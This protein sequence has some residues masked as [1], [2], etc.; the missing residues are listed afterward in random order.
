[1]KKRETLKKS[2]LTL[3]ILP[4]VLIG[5]III[6]V[7]INTIYG[8]LHEETCDNLDKLGNSFIASMDEIYPG[9]YSLKEYEDEKENKTYVLYKGL[10]PI[11]LDFT[12]F[13]NLKKATEVEY[14]IF[15]DTTRYVTTIFDNDNKRYVNSTCPGKVKS[16]VIKDNES[17]FYYNVRIGDENYFTYYIPI[18][19]ASGQVMGMIGLAKAQE[20]V[21]KLV[22]KAVIPIVLVPLAAIIITAIFTSMYS[23]KLT[24]DIRRVREF[25][26]KVSNNNLTATLNPE[27]YKRKDELYDIAKATTDMRNSLKQLIEMDALTGLHNRRYGEVSFNNHWKRAKESNKPFTI[28][29]CDID[30]FKKVNDNYGHE[31]GDEVLKSVSGILKKHMTE[32]GFAIRWGGEEFILCF[33]NDDESTTY[34]KLVS[35]MNEVRNLCV[36]YEDYKIKVTMTFGIAKG[37]VLKTVDE[38]IKIA[39]DKLYSGKENG[40]NQIVL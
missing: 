3:S 12:F 7:S 36:C 23:N 38:I 4:I 37:D 15:Y 21:S 6:A 14:S 29:M 20:N 9:E 32:D 25:I 33:I 28:V 40:R 34:K 16:E 5:V 39:D 8:A 13:D 31:A 10:T 17:K 18:N 22:I 35:I 30:Y 26:S 2:L 1:M 27:I 19:D 11:S 24:N